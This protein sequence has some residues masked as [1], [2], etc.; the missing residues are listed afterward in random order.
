[1]DIFELTFPSMPYPTQ[2]QSYGSGPGTPDN[3]SGAYFS[4]S[5]VVGADWPPDP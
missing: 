5:F 4:M 2:P 3:L 1:M